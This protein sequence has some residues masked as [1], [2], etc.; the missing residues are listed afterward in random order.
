MV[1]SYIDSFEECIYNRKENINVLEIDT[2]KDVGVKQNLTIF[3]GS[4]CGGKI[5]IRKVLS[6][7]WIYKK[8]S[9]IDFCCSRGWKFRWA[10]LVMASL[11]GINDD[12]PGF[13][14]FRSRRDLDP[15]QFF[16]LPKTI[17]MS[18]KKYNSE[19]YSHRFVLIPEGRP[20]RFFS[21]CEQERDEW[22]HLLQTAIRD[23][24]CSKR[25]LEKILI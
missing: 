21:V 18:T 17:V 1:G 14:I 3:Q 12:V 22:V 10:K 5:L 2:L 25:K 8:G 24:N 20:S 23:F 13:A 9:G 15:K 4:N 6:E 16:C 11:P 19:F 7:G